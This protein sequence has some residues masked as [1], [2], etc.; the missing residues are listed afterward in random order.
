MEWVASPPRK[1][2]VRSIF[3]PIVGMTQTDRI[4]VIGERG[5]CHLSGEKQGLGTLTLSA[6]SPASA[7]RFSKST[8]SFSTYD[9]YLSATA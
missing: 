7:F 6:S 8:N 3:S 1:A 5:K 4:F 9:I 2:R